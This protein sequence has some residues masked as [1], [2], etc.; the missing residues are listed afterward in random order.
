MVEWLHGLGI[1][2]LLWQIPLV[3]ARPKP[4]SQAAFDEATMVERGYAVRNADGR[5]H[6]NR[7][8]W[9]PRAVLADFTH[10]EGRRW[11]LEKRRYLLEELGIDGFKTDGGEHPWGHDLRYA[12]GTRGDE[13]NNRYPVEYAAAYHELMR[14]AGV[15]PVT[16]SR[17]GYTGAGAVPLHWAGDEGSTWEAFRSSITAGLT[18]G[19]SGVFFWG[20]DIGGFSGPIPDAELYLRAAA[21]AA[22]CPVMQYHAE[23]N[24]HRLPSGD[25]TPWNIA[26]R[27]GDERV[28]PRYRTLAELRERLVPYLVEQA[29]LAVANS[30]PMMRALA[31]EWPDDPAVWDHQFEYLLGDD[32]LVAPVVEPGVTSVAVYVPQGE[33]IDAWTGEL[34]VGPIVVERTAEVGSIP[35]FV[36]DWDPRRIG[37]VF[38]GP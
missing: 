15:P 37:E 20:W 28:I 16:F 36:R 27:T 10:D 8:W 5:P 18:A 24:F 35:V 2:V 3:R 34:V 9:F 33:W 17:A 1:R 7:A 22:L 19:M 30:R 4:G 23:F 29:A 32:L 6:R 25:R 26:A 13:A 21:M 31:F 12:D 14:S 11:W 38:R